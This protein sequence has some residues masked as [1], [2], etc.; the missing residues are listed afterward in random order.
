MPPDDA[1]AD[2]GDAVFERKAVLEREIA[3]DAVQGIE[4]GDEGS[5]DAC[6]PGATIGF[7]HVAVDVELPLAERLQV[8]HRA[9]APTDQS[10]DFCRPTVDLA[11][12]VSPFTRRS[13]VGQHVVFG[14]HPAFTL[15]LH[16]RRYTFVDTRR[17]KDG[18]ASALI[19]DGTRAVSRELAFHFDRADFITFSGIWHRG[20]PFSIQ[21][22][23]P[24]VG[25]RRSI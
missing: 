8:G 5:G 6:R 2:R 18:R 15:A 25:S 20:G 22:I 4:R 17:A 21:R 11:A 10:L 12:S 9:K 3:S 24:S 23:D 14:R 19:Q 16:P 1:D 13:A 7:K